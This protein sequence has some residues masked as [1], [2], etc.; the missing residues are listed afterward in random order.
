MTVDRSSA[1]LAASMRAVPLLPLPRPIPELEGLGLSP[2]TSVK[3]NAAD[4]KASV[5]LL[6]LAPSYAYDGH[7]VAHYETV[8]HRTMDAYL[9]ALVESLGAPAIMRGEEPPPPGDE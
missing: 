3:G 1:I 4:G 6:Q 5:A 2:V 8:A 7:Y 9:R